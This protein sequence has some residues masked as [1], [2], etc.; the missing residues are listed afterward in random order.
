MCHLWHFADC[1]RGF[2]GLVNWCSENSLKFNAENW[3]Y[4]HISEA[5]KCDFKIDQIFLQKVDYTTNLGVEICSNLKW[6]RHI[7]NKL[8]KAQWRFNC[9][10]HNVP[11]SLPN[12]VKQNLYTSCILSVLLYTSVA[13][14]PR[15]WSLKV[16]R[17]ILLERIVLVLWKTQLHF[18]P[19]IFGQHTHLLSAYWARSS[20]FHFYYFRENLY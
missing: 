11:Y 16:I 19:S 6:S 17:K 8:T 18:S 13:W 10:W 7:R 1:Q 14:F 20:I 9:L 4:F 2:N 5:Q 3:F 12:N 15:F